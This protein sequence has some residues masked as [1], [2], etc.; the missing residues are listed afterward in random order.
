M[1]KIDSRA[2]LSESSPV[3][4]RRRRCPITREKTI[5]LFKQVV[6]VGVKSQKRIVQISLQDAVGTI[7]RTIGDGIDHVVP[8]ADMIGRSGT[9]LRTSSIKTG[10]EEMSLPD[11][12]RIGDGRKLFDKRPL[13]SDRF[14]RNIG[15]GSK[16]GFRDRIL[17]S[18]F[19]E[20]DFFKLRQQFQFPN[21][22]LQIPNEFQMPISNDHPSPRTLPSETTL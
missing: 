12:D 9:G 6:P 1:G 3:P 18:L 5:Y 14:H 15:Q 13:V 19:I 21:S 2:R 16:N 22:K 7:H 8:A 20:I 11:A 4:K 10:N 17:F